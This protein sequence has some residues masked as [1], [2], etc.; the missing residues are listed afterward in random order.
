MTIHL[1][2]ALSLISALLA[3]PAAATEPISKPIGLSVEVDTDS[4]FGGKVN[5][6][7]VTK[8]APASQALVAGVAAGDEVVQVQGKVVPGAEAR[9]L[10]PQMEF[11]PGQ[12]KRITFKRIDGSI[13]EVTFTKFATAAH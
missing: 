12:P 2:L 13:Y 4:L 3:R 1:S 8:V 11:V 9:V 5:K 7:L 6:I 10:K